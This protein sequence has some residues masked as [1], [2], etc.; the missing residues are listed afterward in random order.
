MDP[1]YAENATLHPKSINADYVVSARIQ[2][3]LLCGQIFG[4]SFKLAEATIAYGST[5]RSCPWDRCVGRKCATRAHR[6][7]ASELNRK[8]Q[9]TGLSANARRTRRSIP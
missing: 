3:P 5:C 2:Y 1:R 4:D 9:R 6:P 8:K 7:Q